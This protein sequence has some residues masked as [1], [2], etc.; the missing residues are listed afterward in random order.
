MTVRV[1]INRLYGDSDRQKRRCGTWRDRRHERAGT[2]RDTLR[3]I[4]NG[5][6]K[7]GFDAVL[8]VARALGVLDDLRIRST[9]C[10][11]NSD[12]RELSS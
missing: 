3:R 4:E 5:N 10:A 7:V 8:R 9:R 1:A 2:T 6:P 12:A 11:A